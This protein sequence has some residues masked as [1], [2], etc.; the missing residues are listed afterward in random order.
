M[1]FPKFSVLLFLSMSTFVSAQTGTVKAADSARRSDTLHL[2]N[3]SIQGLTERVSGSVVQVLTSGY[4][5]SDSSR[6][7][8]SA[9]LSPEHG[10]GAGVILTSDG[11]IITNAHVVVDARKIRVMLNDR[12]RARSLEAG[13]GMRG[14]LEGKLIGMDRLTDLALIK[15]DA[16]NL[17]ALTLADSDD[18]RQG[19]IVLAFGSP[20]GLDNSVSMGV[21]SATARQLDPGNPMIYIQTD[22]PINPGNS[23]GPLVDVDGKVVGLNTLIMSQSGGSE[24]IGFAIPSNV[25][26]SIYRQLRKDGHVHR[27]QVGV[28]VRTITPAL[29]KG[30]GLPRDEGVILED[31]IPGGPAEAAGLKVGDIVL[32]VA[33]RPVNDLREFALSL[34]RFRIGESAQLEIL[35]GNQKLT[36]SVPVIERTDDPQRFADMVNE[37]QNLIA[38]LGV[39][40]LTVS[41]ELRKLLPELRIPSGVVVAA[42]T[43]ESNY[44]GDD[45]QQGDV[46]HAVNGKKVTD[47]ASLRAAIEAVPAST[48]LVLQVERGGTLNY[49]VLETD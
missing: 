40:G 33:G 21:V 24:G 34:F 39:M 30:L 42:R 23:G 48:P 28:F 1:F 26:Q 12:E 4:S 37:Q 11:Y 35:R 13:K 47:V 8:T 41:D 16:T 22:A 46:I 32:T 3:D 45:L 25:V 18:L 19:Q 9:V 5:L 14:P 29:A 27:G 36:A 17:P 6:T 7:N 49:L 31:V 44:W 2:F 10:T 20:L 38:K 43:G 15:V